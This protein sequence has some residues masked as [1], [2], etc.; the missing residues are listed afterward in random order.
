MTFDD[1]PLAIPALSSSRLRLRGFQSKDR[2]RWFAWATDPRV[3]GLTSDVPPESPGEFMDML[4][5][6]A[7]QRE[8]GEAIRWAIAGPDDNAIGT[9]GLQALSRR[10][11]RGELGYVLARDQ[12]NQGLATEAAALAIEFGREVL[13]LSRIEATV[14]V[15]NEASARVLAK[16]GFALEGTLRSYKEVRGERRNY[17]M[18]G[19][20][21]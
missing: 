9:I 5:S 17:W 11:R 1:L 18:F 13:F 16:L 7:E 14:M 19:L 3:F 20:V 12:W 4:T 2:D 8:R 6:F 10:H 21:R 15:G